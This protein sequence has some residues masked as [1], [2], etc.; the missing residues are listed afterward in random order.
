MIM[1]V[2]RE[3]EAVR[4]ALVALGDRV[5]SAPD[6]STLP[7]DLLD[8]LAQALDD[9]QAFAD[10]LR[11]QNEELLGHREVLETERQRY[12][13]LFEFAPDGF[14]VTDIHGVI[15]EANRAAGSLLRMDRGFL[16][17]KPVALFV[18]PGSQSAF[19]QHLA[20]LQTQDEV[21]GWEVP[22]DLRTGERI[23]AAM[24]VTVLR[25]A[26]A[27]PTLYWTIRDISERKRL[28][29]RFRA[30]VEAAPAAMM[31]IDSAGSIVLVNTETERLFGYARQ[32]LL[33]RGVEVLV[34]ER[35]RGEHPRLRSQFFAS[36]EARRM[37]AGR[38][39]FGLR[40]DGS[41]F[42]VEIGLNPIETEEGLFV[43]AAILE[44][45][46]RKRNEDALRRQMHWDEALKTIGQAATSLLPLTGILTGGAEAICRVSG[47][48]LAVVRLVDPKTKDLVVAA[49]R[50]VP[51]EYLGVGERIPW[52][53]EVAGTVA[54]S[55]QPRAVG[56][57][58]EQPGVSELSLLAGRAQSL[59]CLPLKAGSRVVGTLTLGH[60]QAEYFSPTDLEVCR[61]AASMLAGAI[62]AE[63]LRVATMK[64]AEEKALLFRELDH[65]VRNHLAALI[66]LLHLGAEGSE[67]T[68]AERLRE[69]AERVARVAEVHNLLTGRG[70][71][72]IEVRELAEGIAK[73]VLLALPGNLTIEWAVS[74][75]TV[76]VPPSQVTAI[77]LILNELLTNCTKH[78]FP[79]R[80]TG[81]VT[82]RVAHEDN[83]I[84]LEVQDDGV[85]LDPAKHPADLGMTIVQTIVTQT[86]RGTVRF[87]AEGGT[88]VTIRFPH[89]EETP[90]GDSP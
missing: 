30:A 77:A 59:A 34:P 15:R 23:H 69:M 3:L 14:L 17:G 51:A 8:Q 11:V 88:Q 85:G 65:R 21:Q 78:A 24:D 73:N 62:L 55:G 42:P 68:A 54:A 53:R 50:G 6:Q 60:D 4:Q 13:Q 33:G 79:G 52:G 66:S 12:L 61:P 36:P 31:M 63:R 64:E 90:E 10:D 80:A 9:L 22:L 82:I 86:L 47:A 40:K 45:T 5:R 84:D 75:D 39:L 43:L 58:E 44:I 89:V 46:E 41:E 38:D 25:S 76:R 57:P 87:A 71:Q 26:W 74:G 37:G 67:G 81:T 27:A 72:P 56:R 20:R 35:F 48:T 19:R 16:V 49:H 28:E 7:L 70:M 32:E 18:R 29:A 1:T 2:E 83:Q